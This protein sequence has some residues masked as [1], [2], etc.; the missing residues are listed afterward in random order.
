MDNEIT[1]HMHPQIPK[2]KHT[3]HTRRLIVPI[4]S[5][6]VKNERIELN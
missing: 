3:S 1:P 5:I 4:T 2:K 6:I